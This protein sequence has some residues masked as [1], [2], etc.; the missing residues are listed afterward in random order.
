MSSDCSVSP[1]GRPGAPLMRARHR[2]HPVVPAG[3]PARNGERPGLDRKQTAHP[4]L[5]RQLGV[6][7]RFADRPSRPLCEYM[8]LPD[9]RTCTY[10]RSKAAVR[11]PGG[12]VD[13]A[14]AAAP[15][16]PAPR[17]RVKGMQCMHGDGETQR[18]QRRRQTQRRRDGV[19]T[20]GTRAVDI[21][22]R[23]CVPS[24][25]T[26]QG[27]HGMGRAHIHPA[28]RECDVPCFVLVSSP[29]QQS[30]LKQ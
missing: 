13:R 4:D 11:V 1:A 22:A 6:A 25:D 10:A 2:R 14:S 26:T 5:A 15:G 7:P 27:S 29:V 19:K 17:R 8:C 20:D 9:V 21:C 28:V 30:P 24:Q 12:T 3:Q 16:R 18:A 23:A